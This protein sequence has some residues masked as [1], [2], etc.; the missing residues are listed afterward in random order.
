MEGSHPASLSLSPKKRLSSRALACLDPRSNPQHHKK[1]K[2]KQKTSFLT[3]YS[4]LEWC[5]HSSVV[6]GDLFPPPPIRFGTFLNIQKFYSAPMR[7][8][9]GNTHRPPPEC[10][11]NSLSYV[12][13]VLSRQP[14]S[15]FLFLHVRQFLEP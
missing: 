13:T 7:Y 1:A 8:F 6:L 12:V 9:T 10:T 5:S 3:L 4:Q 11:V 15:L 2:N 14:L